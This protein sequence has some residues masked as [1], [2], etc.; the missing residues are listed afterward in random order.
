MNEPE[1]IVVPQ[2]ATQV[3]RLLAHLRMKGTIT[4]VE[5]MSVHKISRLAARIFDL[6]NEGYTI[7]KEFKTDPAGDR[8]ARYTLVM[9]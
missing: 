1:I 6:K 5:A 3:T 2:G 4:A 7:T 9:A 8:Y